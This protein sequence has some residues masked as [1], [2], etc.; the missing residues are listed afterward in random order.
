MKTA[1]TAML[2]S[3]RLMPCAAAA[4]L[5]TL[6]PLA[7]TRIVRDLSWVRFADEPTPSAPPG[8]RP[9]CMLDICE[10]LPE[11]MSPVISPCYIAVI[12]VSLSGRPTVASQVLQCGREACRYGGRPRSG[13]GEKGELMTFSAAHALVAARRPRRDERK[14][15]SRQHA[16]PRDGR[17]MSAYQ[18][19][20]GPSQASSDRAALPAASS[21]PCPEPVMQ[22]PDLAER[23]A[24][25]IEEAARL[26][27][28]S[29]DLLY[30]EMRRGT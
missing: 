13:D 24:Y 10:I 14:T 3:I 12:L 9:N 7:R 30:D 20:T 2:A 25:S 5:C 23:L 16:Q 22:E 29:R 1:Q 17:V 27:G 28:L 6:T 4:A 19:R 11:I 18:P 8:V 15:S 21:P 26:T